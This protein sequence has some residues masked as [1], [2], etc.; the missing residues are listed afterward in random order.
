MKTSRLVATN[1]LTLH[2][3]PNGKS[4]S[5]V[6]QAASGGQGEVILHWRYFSN[7][8]H[9]FQGCCTC[10]LYCIFV[11]VMPRGHGGINPPFFAIC[12]EG[13]FYETNSCEHCREFA[14][15]LTLFASLFIS[16]LFTD[17]VCFPFIEFNVT[18][19]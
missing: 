8:S 12:L 11:I 13:Q 17:Y 3:L 15:L 9:I 2:E 5:T 18:Y 10:I 16:L 4:C 19:L 7:C 6:E 14:C 1:S